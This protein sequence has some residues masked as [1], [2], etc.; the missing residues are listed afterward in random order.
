MATTTKA[1]AFSAN[2]TTLSY[3]QA[4]PA[5]NFTGDFADIPF[6]MEVPELGAAPEKIDITTLSDKAKRY[7]PGIKDYGDLVFKFLYDSGDGKNFK[8]LKGFEDDDAN[9]EF[10]IKYPDDTTHTFEAI[11]AVKLDAG[12]LNGALTFSATMMLRSDIVFA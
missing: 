5:G 2:K 6:L 3:R 4:D 7:I 12:S 10:Q 11:P 8:L 1:N 9:L